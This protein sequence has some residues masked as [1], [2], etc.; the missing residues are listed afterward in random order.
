MLGATYFRSL[1][2]ARSQG[3]SIDLQQSQY[4][5]D[6]SGD[7][8]NPLFSSLVARDLAAPAQKFKVGEYSYLKDRGYAFEQKLNENTRGFLDKQFKDLEADERNARIPLMIFNSV[9][10]RDGRK[11]MVSTQPLRFMMKPVMDSGSFDTI[12]PDA[13]DFQSF[14][15]K[16]NP[17]NLRLLTAMRMNATF[18][19]VLPNV[20]LPTQPVVDVMDAGLRDNFGMEGSLRFLQVFKEWIKENTG[21]VVLIQIRDRKSG[22]WEHPFESNDV[23]EVVSRPLLLLQYNWHKM[24]EYNQNDLLSLSQEMMGT[25]LHKLTFQYAPKSEETGA[26]LNFHLTRMEKKAIADALSEDENK[27]AF[28]RISSILK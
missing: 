7:L 10:T 24:Q 20:W 19:Y 15:A 8:L 16:Q 28:T 9:V 17:M 6:I 25:Q 22:G 14:F 1:D 26:A 4:A 12:D 2:L 27:S 23:S 5:N 3:K 11:M 21:G 13:I 18:P